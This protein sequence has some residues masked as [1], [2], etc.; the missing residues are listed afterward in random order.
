MRNKRFFLSCFTFLN[1]AKTG[2]KSSD[3]LKADLSKCFSSQL[4]YEKCIMEAANRA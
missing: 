4:E 1:S 3:S 2:T